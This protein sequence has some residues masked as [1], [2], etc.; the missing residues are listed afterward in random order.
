MNGVRTVLLVTGLLSLTFAWANAAIVEEKYPDGTAKLTFKTNDKGEKDGAYEEFYPDGKA[1]VKS[2]YK[3]DKLDGP[4]KSFH[5]NGKPHI[6]ATY[7]D[8]ILE[9]RV[10]LGELTPA[11]T[12]IAIEH[13]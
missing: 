5:E 3:A 7:K 11:P 12:R 6:T 8:G 4:Y 2:N 10:P 1:K 9:V 13:S